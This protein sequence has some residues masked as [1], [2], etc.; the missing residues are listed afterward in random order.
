MSA[1]SSAPSESTAVW[2]NVPMSNE[3]SHA[4]SDSG[5]SSG[6]DGY[7]EVHHDEL[8]TKSSN[9]LAESS[10]DC[11]PLISMIYDPK[12]Q[13]RLQDIGAAVLHNGLHT[14]SMTAYFAILLLVFRRSAHHRADIVYGSSIG[15]VIIMP[16]AWLILFFRTHEHFAVNNLHRPKIAA[17]AFI[18]IACF[19]LGAFLERSVLET[20]EAWLEHQSGMETVIVVII[21]ETFSIVFTIYVLPF[22]KEN[23]TLGRRI[24][25]GVFWGVLWALTYISMMAGL[26]MFAKV[27]VMVGSGDRSSSE[28]VMLAMSGL[29]FKIFVDLLLSLLSR[30][31]FE[32]L[33]VLR[34]ANH[35][36]DMVLNKRRLTELPAD[37]EE[38][39]CEIAACLY[40]GFDFCASLAA[41]LLLTALP[42][43]RWVLGMACVQGIQELAVAF[44]M[45][46]PV[47]RKIER[48]EGDEAHAKANKTRLTLKMV[49]FVS[50][51]SVEY[52][53]MTTACVAA[54]IFQD[55]G[56]V[57]GFGSLT[58]EQGFKIWLAQVLPELIVDFLALTL[59]N[60]L[61]INV[62]PVYWHIQ[63]EFLQRFCE[64]AF[65]S[66]WLCFTVLL[67]LNRT[68]GLNS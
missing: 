54:V 59:V 4:S 5:S 61:H 2:Y 30:V 13:V 28:K 29:F 37:Q 18:A 63:G 53:V 33:D 50:D 16:I 41:K 57:T 48:S 49:K 67:A 39:L 14:S 23:R 21:F 44:V 7:A 62:L 36:I 6:D 68:A 22:Y 8:E 40:F 64:C 65:A 45:I 19:F 66:M 55:C 25:E 3:D 51:M 56:N 26:V 32:N 42:D 24:G 17:C 34:E 47:V 11:V 38:K 35:E 52:L 31:I 46:V 15:F 1:R 58:A 60:S 43:W 20:D 10:K 12:L 9:W 27:R